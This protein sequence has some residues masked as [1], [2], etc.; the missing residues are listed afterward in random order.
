MN[1]SAVVIF[2]K[3]TTRANSIR[4]QA[5]QQL[6]DFFWEI[7]FKLDSQDLVRRKP[8]QNN[9]PCKDFL[10]CIGHQNLGF[11]ACGVAKEN[12]LLPFLLQQCC[13]I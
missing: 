1:A 10:R 4:L 2:V 6:D 3:R 11:R 5:M 7:R 8:G 9:M 12:K 13:V